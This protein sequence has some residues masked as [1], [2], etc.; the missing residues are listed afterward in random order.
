MQEIEVRMNSEMS[1][2][3][4]VVSFDLSQYLYLDNNYKLIAYPRTII[5]LV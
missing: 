4:Y 5:S 3:P 2:G 1:F